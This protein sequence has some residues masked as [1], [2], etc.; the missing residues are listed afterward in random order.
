M[1]PRHAVLVACAVLVATLAVA[2][3]ATSDANTDEVELARETESARAASTAN[4]APVE[5]EAS[6]KALIET[7]R[8]VVE[9]ARVPYSADNLLARGAIVL[10]ALSARDGSPVLARSVHLDFWREKTLAAA[11]DNETAGIYRAGPLEPG[12][13]RVAVSSERFDAQEF[14]LVVPDDATTLVRDLVMTEPLVLVV[15]AQT[16]AGDPLATALMRMPEFDYSYF[17]DVVATAGPV[18][19]DSKVFAV[20][21]RGQDPSAGTF[22]RD[23]RA[24]DGSDMVGTLRV[25]ALPVFVH[26][27][28]AGTVL[29]SVRADEN[30]H[31]VPLVLDPRALAARLASVRVRVIDAES[32]LAV[33]GADVRANPRQTKLAM[34]GVTDA[35][36]VCVIANISPELVAFEIKNSAYAPWSSE[37][38]VATGGLADL[39]TVQLMRLGEL[40]VRV[41]DRAGKPVEHQLE[42][43]DLADIGKNRK[44]VSFD[45]S[46][47]GTAHALLL[48][49][50]RYVVRSRESAFRSV[51]SGM[52]DGAR[53]VSSNDGTSKFDLTLQVVPTLVELDVNGG[54]EVTLTAVTTSVC[55]FTLGFERAVAVAIQITT[56]DGVP[57][58]EP[59]SGPNQSFTVALPPGEYHIKATTAGENGETIE[60][61]FSV[62][63][64]GVNDVR[65]P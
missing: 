22:K 47:A 7:A 58:H 46:E 17:L 21:V 54:R 48:P 41:V 33:A 15:R 56:V 59:F 43:V 20:D 42:A 13:Y 49:K 52:G 37:L 34:R 50:R 10:G 28:W 11:L 65:V 31:E 63:A 24:L 45:S 27:T 26:L 18:E 39:G 55:T 5:L 32:G 38:D 19:L 30:M 53:A 1:H 16:P 4:A 3:Y 35:N 14:E 8:P 12:T 44:S 62:A 25:R 29:T 40:R 61:A 2:W 57:V 6:A 36:G 9:T 60:R 64:T 51:F 23:L